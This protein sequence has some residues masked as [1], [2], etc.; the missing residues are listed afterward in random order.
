M[1]KNT[2]DEQDEDASEKSGRSFE[3]NGLEWTVFAL[4]L[5]LVLAVTGYLAYHA[6]QQ[7]NTPPT[8][9]FRF[10]DAHRQDSLYVLTVMIRNTGDQTAADVHVT[11]TSGSEQAE[12]VITY[13]PRHSE[14]EGAVY[15][16]AFPAAPTARVSS[17]SL[18]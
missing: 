7:E 3:K 5:A 14:R 2:R 16:R 11:V 12:V 8:F 10:E 4:S 15:F 17:Y 13:V 1:P 6:V 18:P 9:Q